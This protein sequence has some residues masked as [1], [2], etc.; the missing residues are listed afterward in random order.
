MSSY[1]VLGLGVTGWSVV[2]YLQRRGDTVRVMDAHEQPKFLQEAIMLLGE[3]SVIVGGFCENTIAQAEVVVVSPGIPP[4]LPVIKNIVSRGQKIITDLDLFSASNKVPCIL[5]TG[6]NGK[7]TVVSMLG[8]IL[9]SVNIKN[10]VC[11]NIGAPILDF[12]DEKVD[13]F[14]IEVSSYTLYYTQSF[15]AFVGIVLNAG[16]DHLQWHG[17]IEN[18]HAAKYK[19]YQF[20]QF[21]VTNFDEYK[22]PFDKTFGFNRDS[23]WCIND[24][25]DI[26][27]IKQHMYSNTAGMAQNIAAVGAII[28]LIIDIDKAKF[29]QAIQSFACLPHRCQLFLDNK[30]VS[31][32]ND[33]KSTNLHSTISAVRAYCREKKIL[34][35]LGGAIKD[36][37]WHAGLKIL[38]PLVSGFVM[39][40]SGSQVLSEIADLYNINHAS[41]S[42]LELAMRNIHNYIVDANLVLLSPGG[43]SFDEFNNFEVRGDF[44][45]SRVLDVTQ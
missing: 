39:F 19:L 32:I 22:G 24:Q 30:K 38:K 18:Y 41:F 2:K 35:L 1:V 40:G 11:G 34:L 15:Q 29:I 10:R 8:H 23:D 17:D 26:N 42:T 13:Y 16:L 4:T 14:I 31:W 45:M 3:D 25:G 37:D 33:S 44:F 36:D 20:S 7:S 12:I 21:K 28:S 27:Y 5:V 6:T 9:S 43:A